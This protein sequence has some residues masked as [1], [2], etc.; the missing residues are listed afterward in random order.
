M[1]CHKTSNNKYFKCPPMMSDGRHFTDYRPSCSVNSLIQNNTNITSSYQYREYLTHNA[2]KLMDLNRVYSCQ[3]NCCGPC[4]T[5]YNTGT[6]LD[7]NTNR[8]CNKNSCIIN[9][10]KVNGLG[11]GR[12]YNTKNSTFPDKLPI[13]QPYNC[14]SD[15][16]DSFNYYNYID[17][18]AQGEMIPRKTIPSG[19][20]AMKGGDP[21]AF[22]L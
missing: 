7:E 14:C 22:N 1:S 13:N 8:V 15:T 6:M 17:N 19:G 9:N 2:S 11:Q 4:K 3:K 18:K 21:M 16:N 12:Q 5:P 10:R 20:D